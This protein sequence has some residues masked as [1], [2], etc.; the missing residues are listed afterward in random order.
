MSQNNFHF[1]FFFFFLAFHWSFVSCSQLCTLPYLGL[2]GRQL[3]QMSWINVSALY[4]WSPYKCM[5]KTFGETFCSAWFIQRFTHNFRALIDSS[6]VVWY[7]FTSSRMTLLPTCN[8]FLFTV[9]HSKIEE[10]WGFISS[11]YRIQLLFMSNE[12]IKPVR[13]T[14]APTYNIPRSLHINETTIMI[15]SCNTAQHPEKPD[16]VSRSVVV[17]FT[18]C[19]L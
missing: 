13:E 18:T 9:W 10:N 8:S 6:L 2:C 12:V 1:C 7:F 17:I 15:S 5:Y 19:F 11:H 3:M 4:R 14:W 16:S